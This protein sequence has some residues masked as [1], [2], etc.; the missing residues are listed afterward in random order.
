VK[1]WQILCAAAVLCSAASSKA[2]DVALNP[3]VAPFSGEDGLV[4]NRPRA[5]LHRDLSTSLVIDYARDPLVVELRRGDSGTEAA[6]LVAHQLTGHARVAFGLFDELVLMAGLD[7]ALD[8]RGERFVVPG[9]SAPLPSADGPGLGDARVGVRYIPF[10]RHKSLFAWALQGQLTFP[11]AEAASSSQ[12]LTG[13]GNVSFRPE[14]LGELRPGPYRFNV[15][16]GAVVREEGSLLGTQIGHQL[17]FALGGGVEL[18]GKLRAVQLLGELHGATGF[19][20]FFGRDVTPL[21]LLFG[22]RARASSQWQVGA[23]AGPGLSRG[24]GSPDFRVLASVSFVVP[25]ILDE[26]RDGV[27]D[28]R[29]RCPAVREDRDGVEDFDGCPDPDNDGDG[30]RDAIDSCPMDR[31]DMDKFEDFDGC[32]E[33]DNDEDGIEDAIDHCPLEPEDRDVFQ[34]EDGCPDDA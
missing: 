34:D 32:P 11:T 2:Q 17:T 15:A 16:L 12:N 23:A 13:E 19:S 33:R 21:E 9:A 29:D 20:K 5:L 7:V 25:H 26:D 14:L 28:R 6:S 22:L 30:I 1:R 10:G 24:V 4:L 8:M 18:P 3:Y 31:E 27:N